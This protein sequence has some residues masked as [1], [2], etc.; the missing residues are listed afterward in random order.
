[1]P[2]DA[3]DDEVSGESA[4]GGGVGRRRFLTYLV[5]APTLTVAVRLG[6]DLAAP[7]TAEAL[8]SPPSV[9]NVIDLGDALILAGSL[10][11]YDL[12]LEIT[13]DSRVAVQLPRVEVGQGITTTVAMLVAEEL[14]ARLVD[15]DVALCDADPEVLF[16]QM[17]AASN[18]VRSLYTP[19]RTVAAAARARLVTAAAQ[20]WNLPAS[21]LTTKD[22]AVIAPDGR[23]ASY[24]SL[25]AAAATVVLPAVSAAP[26]GPSQFT[27]IGQP[28][29]RI[30]AHEIVTGAAKYAMDLDVPGAMPTVVARPPT[31]NG[32]VATVDSSVASGMPGVVAITQIPTGI[33]VTAETFDQAFKA[34]DALSITW[35]DGPIAA[36]SDADIR[37]LLRAA[38]L[39][40]TVPPLFSL[41]VDGEFDFAF[42]SHAPMEV[43][44]AVADV[45]A[46]E[47]EIWFASKS[48]VVAL[49]TIAAAIG[50][51]EDAVTV[52]VV[53]GGGSFGRRL[54]FDAALEAAQVSKAIGQPVKLMWSRSDDIRHGRMRPASH[55][56][57]RATYLLGSV[58]TYEH[59]VATVKTDF[60]HGLGEALTAAGFAITGAGPS[61]V[62]FTLTESVPYNFGVATELL[63]EVPL[64][65]HTGSWRSVY[66]GLVAVAD[67]IMVDEI[68]GKL[69]QD[70]VTFRRSTLSSARAKAVLNTVASAGS[71]GRAMPAGTAQGVAIHEEF[72]S[73]VACLVEIDTT[74]A[75]TG[76][77]VTK[78]V[79]AADVGRAVNPRGLEAQLMGATVDGISLTL[80]AGLHIDDG[81]VRE[82]SF[83]DFHYARMRHTPREFEVH[84][85]PPTGDPGGAGE[86]AFPAAAA[87]V[88]NAYA[89]ATGTKPRSFPLSG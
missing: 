41:H 26:K 24:G 25:T 49:Q 87:A 70:P 83:S 65:M 19:M 23:T 16:N 28:T 38:T 4:A 45:R 35:N 22:T 29:T 66:S 78:A 72:K 43:L 77:R 7:G 30:D 42:V 39:P 89:R 52:H 13:T 8:T 15:V 60:R 79:V 18:S 64:D 21:T 3:K 36:L 14:D 5:A 34:R 33:A 63:T 20:Q 9:P 71:W 31:I 53:R 12:C 80:Q 40:L 82:S 57:I 67:E 37:N 11:A 10:T 81:A 84:I 32:T 17:T 62:V 61:E 46:D 55:H 56:K 75:A 44:G 51:P 1:M 59:H 73:C 6:L 85:L 54:F 69:G 68:A 88:A 50:L 27:V 47:A 58:L 48:P 76:P 2:K 74:N 86:L